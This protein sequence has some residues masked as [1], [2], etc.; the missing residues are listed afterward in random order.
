MTPSGSRDAGRVRQRIV[1]TIASLAALFVLAGGTAALSG[2]APPYRILVTN[3]DG[4]R[5]PGLAALAQA[6][7]P[8]GEITI[9]APTENQSGT[10]HAITLN[11]PIY[12]ERV[13]VAGHQATGLAATP[14]TCVRVALARL[15]PVKPDL[16][17]SGVNRGSNI[18][19]KL[20]SLV[21]PPVAM[22]TALC[23]RK[24]TVGCVLSMLPSERKHLSGAVAPGMTRGLYR[25][26]IPITWPASSSV[27]GS[28]IRLVIL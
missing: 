18:R 10:G 17:V 26:V 14:A 20:I 11:D 3:D 25:A 21:L 27:E 24:F 22:I 23:A 5:S 19:R 16:V 28:R 8:L 2:Q 4:V 13:D 15:L 6:L 9:V 7:A 1:A 12:I